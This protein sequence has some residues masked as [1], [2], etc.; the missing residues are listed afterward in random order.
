[1]ASSK[2]CCTF[3]PPNA[4]A[5]YAIQQNYE[6]WHFYLQ[7]SFFLCNFAA[8]NERNAV[9]PE[10]SRFYGIVI[11]MYNSEHNPPHFHIRY[12]DYRATMD[13]NTGEI[14]GNLPRRVLNLVYEWFDQ[15]KDELKENWLRMEKG[16]E[17][18]DIKPLD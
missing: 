6:K 10:I 14:N 3:A 8:Q 16:E 13:I 7:V 17:I 12:N 1:M 5:V 18:I 11:T 15:H 4:Q 9:M 2:N